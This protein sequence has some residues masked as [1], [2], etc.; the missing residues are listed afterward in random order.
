MGLLSPSVSVTQYRVEGRLPSPVTENVTAA[1]QNNTIDDIDNDASEQTFG[2]TPFDDPYGPDFEGSQFAIDPAWVFALR[3]DKKHIP[4][5]VLKKHYNVEVAKRLSASGRDYLSRTEKKQVKE[6]VV[7][8][9]S[10]RIPATPN[11]YD[12]LWH[13]EEGRL[14]FFSNLKAANEALETLFTRS[15][16]LRLVRLFPYTA[17]LHAGLSGPDRDSLDQLK[18]THFME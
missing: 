16:P 10:T 2:W 15:F 9:L 11:V 14:W 4:S 18:P 17:G 1:L 13:Y 8:V 5:K 7:T 6:H 12:V 3:L